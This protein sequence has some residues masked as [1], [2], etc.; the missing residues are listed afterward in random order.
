MV[1][2]HNDKNTDICLA[3]NYVLQEHIVYYYKNELML[4]AI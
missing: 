1:V 3:V 2:Q 4:K